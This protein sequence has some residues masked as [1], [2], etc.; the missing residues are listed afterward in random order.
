MGDLGFPQAVRRHVRLDRGADRLEIGSFVCDADEDVAADAL[1]VNGLHAVLA[2][3]EILAHVAGR[4]QRAVLLIGPLVIGT[5]EARRGTGFLGADA[6][7]TVAAGIVEG[8]DGAVTAAD[9]QDRVIAD[10]QGE[11]LA[12]LLDLAI[13]ADEQ[14]VAIPD[15]FHVQLEIVLVD[16]EGLLEAETLAAV[17]QLP[18]NLI[19]QIHRHFLV[20]S[21]CGRT[22]KRMRPRGP[23]NIM[24]RTP[25]AIGQNISQG[26]FPGSGVVLF[27]LHGTFPGG[28]SGSVP[29]AFRHAFNSTTVAGAAPDGFSHLPASQFSAFPSEAAP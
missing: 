23:P 7:A 4:H 13:M 25:A 26:W 3:V 16:I 9:D 17:F 20:N 2:L 12:A 5:D 19:A 22:W 15:H 11:I 28:L 18:Q 6:V 1:T 10:L 24:P 29:V 27:G 21:A 14:P 8:A